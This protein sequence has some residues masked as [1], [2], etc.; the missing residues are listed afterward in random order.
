MVEEQRGAVATFAQHPPVDDCL[1][2]FKMI[3]LLSAKL[4]WVYQFSVLT[5]RI[6]SIGPLG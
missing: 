4:R 1:I 6:D 3:I 2:V 5:L